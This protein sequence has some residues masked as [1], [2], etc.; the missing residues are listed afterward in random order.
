MT[1]VPNAKHKPGEMAKVY[2]EPK[3]TKGP[4]DPDRLETGEIPQVAETYAYLNT[5]YPIMNEHQLAI[6][7][8]TI[9]SRGEPHERERHHRRARALPPR[10]RAGQDGPR[11]HPHRRRADQGL[12]LQRLGRVL[13][14]RR[15]EGG[16]A[17]RDPRPGQGQEGRRLG[18]PARPRRRDRGLGQRRAHPRARPGE[19]GLLHGLGQ[20]RCPS[21]R[22][23][24]SGRRRAASPSISP[25]PTIP[26]RGTSLYCRRREWRVLS[27]LAPS[28]RLNP[29]SENY[30]VLGQARQ[31]GRRRRGPGHLPRHLRRDRVRHDPD[32]DGGQ[33][34][35]GDRQEPG[36]DARS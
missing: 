4:N 1:I 29:E 28:L 5:A 6:G 17:L 9:G 20:R 18:G 24:A 32:P 16:L 7:E 13:H 22:S 36:R 8:T 11:G 14:L 25:T 10:P 23:W 33:P 34:E 12:G 3:R 21:P 26:I 19:R 31:E 27:L 2:Y 30:P 15:H 35:R